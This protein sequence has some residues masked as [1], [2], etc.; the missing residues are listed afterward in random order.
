MF[1][2]QN[3]SQALASTQVTVSLACTNITNQTTNDSSHL[4]ATLF[5]LSGVR[6]PGPGC[7][8]TRHRTETS[9]CTGMVTSRG[10]AE[11]SEV[12]FTSAG[13]L[14]V[15]GGVSIVWSPLGLFFFF[16]AHGLISVFLLLGRGVKQEKLVFTILAHP[17]QNKALFKR[18][19]FTSLTVLWMPPILLDQIILP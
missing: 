15:Q 1:G 7:P 11:T 18:A 13:L 3:H 9:V 5:G 17:V 12:I 19:P 14:A 16:F 8:D 2:Y 10:E 4:S 6:V